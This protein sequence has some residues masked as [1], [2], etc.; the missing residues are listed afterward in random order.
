[1]IGTHKHPNKY[2]W[3]EMLLNYLCPVMVFANCNAHDQLKLHKKYFVFQIVL[4]ASKVV[5]NYSI[6]QYHALFLS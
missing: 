4:K 6:D 2:K 3:Y 5:L 1:M